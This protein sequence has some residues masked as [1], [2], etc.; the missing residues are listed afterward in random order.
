VMC[1]SAC[2]TMD[3]MAMPLTVVVVSLGPIVMGATSMRARNLQPLP[4]VLSIQLSASVI[5]DTMV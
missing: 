2:A 5:V 3:T 1:P 4:L